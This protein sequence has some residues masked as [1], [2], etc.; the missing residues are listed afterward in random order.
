ME[1]LAEFLND[2]DLIL[3][4]S[5]CQVGIESTII[6]CTRGNPTI[7]R[8]GAISDE[9]IEET[10]KLKTVKKSSLNNIRA[11]GLL[12]KH[13]SP[14]ARIQ[15]DTAPVSGQGYLALSKFETPFGVIRLASPETNE[16]FARKFYQALR[17][18]DSMGLDSLV[19]RLP[20]GG[21]ISVAIRDRAK[22]A[23]RGR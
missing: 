6:D 7:L 19:I 18:A 16:E 14:K 17:D 23:S 4:G 10:I 1:E 5:N 2:A 12:E 9:M 15:L 11:S 13:Y 8:P 20:V 3:D 22:R 21:G